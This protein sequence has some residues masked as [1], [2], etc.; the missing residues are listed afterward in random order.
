MNR[1]DPFIHYSIAV[2][3]ISTVIQQPFTSLESI[4]TPQ[5]MTTLLTL[6]SIDSRAVDNKTLAGALFHAFPKLISHVARSSSA[7]QAPFSQTTQV[8]RRLRLINRTREQLRLRATK[9]VRR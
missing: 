2:Y 4:I 7:L 9:G 3:A 6:S 8:V 1:V 5:A